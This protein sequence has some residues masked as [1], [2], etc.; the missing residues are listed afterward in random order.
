MQM[1]SRGSYSI[2]AWGK[3]GLKEYCSAASL[4]RHKNDCGQC[5]SYSEGHY[6]CIIILFT[7]VHPIFLIGSYI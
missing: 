4:W 5:Y 3:E 7:L 1:L 6:N 2:A